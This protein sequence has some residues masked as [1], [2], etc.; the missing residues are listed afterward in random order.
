MTSRG[1]S[2]AKSH[3][4]RRVSLRDLATGHHGITQSP[5]RSGTKSRSRRSI[6]HPFQVPPEPILVHDYFRRTERSLRDLTVEALKPKALDACWNYALAEQ[7]LHNSLNLVIYEIAIPSL[8][9]VRHETWHTRES[10]VEHVSSARAILRGHPVE[11]WILHVKNLKT[12]PY[13][14]RPVENEA[15]RRYGRCLSAH[16]LLLDNGWV[17]VKYHSQTEEPILEQKALTLNSQNADQGQDTELDAVTESDDEAGQEG[18]HGY[19]TEEDSQ[20]ED[21][22]RLGVEGAGQDRGALEQCPHAFYDGSEEDHTRIGQSLQR[23]GQEDPIVSLVETES[24]HEAAGNEIDWKHGETALGSLTDYLSAISPVVQRAHLAP[25]QPSNVRTELARIQNEAIGFAHSSAD[26]LKELFDGLVIGAP[27]LG[28]IKDGDTPP[29][30]EPAADAIEDSTFPRG[31][32]SQAFQH[33]FTCGSQCDSGAE[34]LE[35][36]ATDKMEMIPLSRI[37]T[38]MYIN[39]LLQEK[40]HSPASTRLLHIMWD[41]KVKL[42][43]SLGLKLLDFVMDLKVGGKLAPVSS[44]TLPIIADT[45]EITKIQME[46]YNKTS[47]RLNEFAG[48]LNAIAEA[49]GVNLQEAKEND[50]EGE[51]AGAAAEVEVM[52]PPSD[53]SEGAEQPFIRST[54]TPPSRTIFMTGSTQPKGIAAQPRTQDITGTSVNL[55]VGNSDHEKD[56]RSF[57]EPLGSVEDETTVDVFFGCTCE[58]GSL[59]HRQKSKVT[60]PASGLQGD[61]IPQHGANHS[62]DAP[63]EAQPNEWGSGRDCEDRSKDEGNAGQQPL[64]RSSDFEVVN[65]EAPAMRPMT[66]TLPGSNAD[67]ESTALHRALGF[68]S[69]FIIGGAPA[70]QAPSFDAARGVIG[71]QNDAGAFRWVYPALSR[72]MLTNMGRV[73]GDRE[74]GVNDTLPSQSVSPSLRGSSQ[75]V[76]PHTTSSSQSQSHHPQPGHTYPQVHD[77]CLNSSTGVSMPMQPSFTDHHRSAVAPYMAPPLWNPIFH[78]SF[79]Y[80]QGSVQVPGPRTMP[81]GRSMTSEGIPSQISGVDSSIPFCYENWV[82]GDNETRARAAAGLG[83]PGNAGFE[84][85]GPRGPLNAFP[86][87]YHEGLWSNGSRW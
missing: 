21:G 41:E 60:R 66:N 29:T 35:A 44:V 76:L 74:A 49:V 48:M 52:T 70:S 24:F 42:D 77:Q 64:A 85:Y 17:R 12:R 33:S 28:V 10:V 68:T 14:L 22:H 3:D 39:E 67:P 11:I 26:E 53:A 40:D 38:P 15:S 59:Q 71:D 32:E 56:G 86:T 51:A 13:S 78:P 34:S 16:E 43:E 7:Y 45:T 65:S 1:W 9:Y 72:Q 30:I 57:E 75:R 47:D 54:H 58:D 8:G 50:Q 84:M 80:V 2:P 46:A 62:L 19:D 18:D 61:S 81:S 63:R 5:N 27:G 23:E 36:D 79:G 20:T 31:R 37:E 4:K 83:L 55:A 6:T 25:G 73:R 69:E 82:M 87:P